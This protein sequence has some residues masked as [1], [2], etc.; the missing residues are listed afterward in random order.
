M[1]SPSPPPLPSLAAADEP[2]SGVIPLG[3]VNE[4]VTGAQPAS[5]PPASVPKTTCAL[6]TCSRVLPRASHDPH[7]VCIACR[8]FYTDADRCEECAGWEVSVVESARSYHSTLRRRRSRYA[9]RHD[10]ASQ[11]GASHWQAC[12]HCLLLVLLSSPFSLI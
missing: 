11:A 8:G 9:H 5:L 4:G 2:R 7:T 1:S 3:E 6:P 10:S 12:R